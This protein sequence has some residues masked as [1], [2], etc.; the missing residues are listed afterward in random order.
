[1]K[2]KVREKERERARESGVHDFDGDEFV[3]VLLHQICQ[4]IEESSSLVAR[5]LGPRALREGTGKV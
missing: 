1:M 3:S 2:E 4:A 5:H